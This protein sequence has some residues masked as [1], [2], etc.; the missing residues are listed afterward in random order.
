MPA[1]EAMEGEDSMFREHAVDSVA[2]PDSINRVAPIAS[3]RLWLLLLGSSVML[4]AFMA[5]GF[6]GSIPLSVR[7]TGILIEG[8][9]V[10]AAECPSDGWLVSV[11]VEVG[12][13]VEQGQVLAV[14][15][16]RAL[17]A[18]LADAQAA[19][20]RLQEQ[21]ARM[22]ESEEASSAA[23]LQALA[24]REAEANRRAEQA[25]VTLEQFDRSIE[26]KRDLVR[27]GLLAEADLLATVNTHMEIARGVS[28]ARSEQQRVVTERAE[29]AIRHDQARQAR[30]N[31]LAEARSALNQAEAR[32]ALERHVLAP[33]PGRVQ[34]VLRSVGD[35]CRRGGSVAVISDAS[36]GR[37]RC[38]AFFPLSEGKRIRA[39]MGARVEPSIADRER[40]GLVKGAV[41]EVEPLVGTRESMSRV[42]DS[43]EFA[44]DIERRY[45]GIVSAVIDLEED[46]GTPTGLRWTGG[47]GYPDALPPGTLCEVDVVT[48][49]VAPVAL[50]LPWLKRAFDG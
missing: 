28:E 8:R 15:G 11:S 17:E 16:N 41:R 22:V 29:L 2:S 44:Q 21:H 36:D 13:V 38:Y 1:V 34:Q 30:A 24:V 19:V 4:A 3:P 5:W 37:L 43:P 45:G 14:I 46:P 18:Q 25:A 20:E 35:L 42:I 47:M 12:D 48:E 10:V 32:M 27:Q 49:E 7:G 50:L 31:A 26:S 33:R 6:L 23:A 39:A 9:R 40:Y